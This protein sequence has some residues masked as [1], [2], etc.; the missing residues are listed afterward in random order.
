MEQNYD[1]GLSSNQIEFEVKVGTVGTAYTAVYLTKKDE[2]SEKIIES[3]ANSGN[4]KNQI[5]GTAGE[6]KTRQLIIRTSIDF[7]NVN[8]TQWNNS[9]AAIDISY[10]LKGGFAGNLSFSP[11]QNDIDIVLDG[12]EVVI[13]KAI[14][15]I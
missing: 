3:N 5:I 4:I 2:K 12:K 7:S 14:L 9:I 1:T 6:L 15:L 11:E 13:T 10:S 8:A